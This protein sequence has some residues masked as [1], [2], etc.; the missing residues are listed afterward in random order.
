MPEPILT[1]EAWTLVVEPAT[2]PVLIEG[3]EEYVITLQLPE[4]VLVAAGEQGPPG[5]AGPPGSG[6]VEWQAN[7]W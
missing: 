2:T 6:A 1:T 5:P 3:G 4:T 7:D